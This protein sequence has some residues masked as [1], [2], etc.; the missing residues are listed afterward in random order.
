MPR[1]ALILIGVLAAAAIGLLVVPALLLV[2]RTDLPFERAY[3]NAIVGFVAG[4][5]AGDAKLPANARASTA[6]RYAYIGSCATCH[7]ATGDGKGA[8]GQQTYPPATDL[9][10]ADAKDKTDAE[11]FWIT[12]NGLSFTAMP[13]FGRQYSEADLWAIVGYIRTLQQ[14]GRS[15]TINIPTPT[16]A[17]LAVADPHGTPVARGAAVYFAQGCQLCHGAVGNAPGDLALHEG[18]SETIRR[19]KNG[20]PAYGTDRISAADLRDLLAYVATF[21]GG[22]GSGD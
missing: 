19:G 1:T 11:L 4:I 5:S 22:G 20:M 17:Q 15:A 6:G 9:T 18:D 21:R 7:G 8:F 2:H 10:S 3:A 14:G 13:G 16:E 12:K